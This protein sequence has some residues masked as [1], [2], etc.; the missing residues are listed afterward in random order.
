MTSSRPYLIRAIY[1]WIIDNQQTPHILV[2]STASGVQIPQGYDSD[3]QIVLNV[4]PIA[5]TKLIL[6][7]KSVSFTG[8]FGGQAHDIHV[9]VLAV[10]GIYARETGQGM[11]FDD[12]NEPVPEDDVPP[13]PQ[14]GDR[15]TLKVV[16]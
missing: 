3:G 1:E 14:P 7:N 6:D 13:K 11:V 12:S 2:N 10:K 4:A 9:P 5:V 8:R 16:K 15:P